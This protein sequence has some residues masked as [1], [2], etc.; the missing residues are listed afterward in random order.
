[1]AREQFSIDGNFPSLEAIL[2]QYP[3]AF[4]IQEGSQ[5]EIDLRDPEA[6]ADALEEADVLVWT[7]ETT[8][9]GDNGANAIARLFVGRCECGEVSGVR[10][11]E[12]AAVTVEVVP[13]YLRASH[14]A[15]GNAG[16]WPANGSLRLRVSRACATVFASEGGD[17]ARIV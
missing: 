7:D 11:E 8:A 2:A 16:E 9:E 15:A 5:D 12:R 17:W 14:S 3:K 6:V 10:C 4:A 13:E 1:M